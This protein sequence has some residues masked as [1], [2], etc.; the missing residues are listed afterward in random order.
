[1]A[2]GARHGNVYL[3]NPDQDKAEAGYNFALAVGI[4]GFIWS[5]ALLTTDVLDPVPE[6]RQTINRID[7]L[8]SAF[9]FFMYF[10]LFCVLANYWTSWDNKDIDKVKAGAKGNIEAAIAFAFFSWFPVWPAQVYFLKQ[11]LKSKR[12]NYDFVGSADPDEE[13]GV[14]YAAFGEDSNE[15]DEGDIGHNTFQ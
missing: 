7:I 4:M 13:D 10:V 6:L 8:M 14:A 12:S 2:S 15:D 1:M 9:I 3:L 5:I 11:R